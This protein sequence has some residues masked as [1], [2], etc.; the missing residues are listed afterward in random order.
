MNLPPP[1]AKNKPVEQT[2]E[3]PKYLKEL[4][5]K[6]TPVTVKLD[7]ESTVK[8]IIE[9]YDSAFIR[10][11][12]VGEPNLFLFKHHIKYIAEG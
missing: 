1:K 10:L 6:Q 5:E 3:E 11:T 2:F 4:I 7:D 9:Y 8:G 12:R